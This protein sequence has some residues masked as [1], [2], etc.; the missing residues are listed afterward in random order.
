MVAQAVGIDLGTTFSCVGVFQH[1]KVEI[2][3]NEQGNRTTPSYVAFNDTERLI[4]DSAKNQIAMNPKN[5]VFDAKRLIGRKFNDPKIQQDMRLWPFEVISDGGNPKIVVEYK[6]EKRKFTPEEISSMVLSKMKEIAETYLGGIV[7]DAV[8]TVPAYFNDAQRQATKDAGAIAALNVLRIIN[9]PTAAALAYGLDKELKGEKNVLIFDL[10]GGTFDVS[11]L[12]ISEGS[13]FEVSSTAGDTH[14][15]GEDFDCRMVDHF[16]QEFERKYKKDIKSNPKALRRL[17]TACERAKRTLSSNTEASLEVDALHEGID[18]YSKITRARFEELCSDLFRQTLGPVDRALKDAGLN[19]RE[20]HDVVMVG[21]S[22]RIPKIQRLLQD[23]FS[24]KVLNLSINPDEAV[25]YGAA[26]QAAIL[27]GS[28][29]TRIQDVLLV[30][31]T[32]LSLGIETAGGIMTKLVDRNTRI[33]IA[34]KKIFTT[35]SDN[36]PAVTIQVFEGERAL[37]KDN[38]LLG[39]FN[40]TGIPPAPRGVPQVEVTFDIDA[41]GILS[42]SAQD[43]STGRSEQIT[44][45][46]DRGRLNKKEIEKMLQDAEKFKAEDEMV[47]KKVEVRNQLEAYLF[48]CK[49]AAES[50]G[51]RLTDDEKDAVITECSNQ[52][53]WLETNGDA[54]LAELE[55]RL[56]SAQAICQSAMMK[57]HAGGPSY[58]RPVSS[59]GPRVEEV[60]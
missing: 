54:S 49:T 3:A 46:N 24:G 59:G 29:D 9:E 44:I 32:P 21:G 34:Q 7:K 41:N 38:N 48:G 55:S 50:A 47:R 51:T 27:T 30:D 1:G 25:A 57:L 15:G 37:T 53:L 60:D 23:F 40:L 13:L 11:I 31:I 39:V 36:Q 4:G 10:G 19:T 42:V 14:L 12:Q 26:V 58:G 33:P 6:G 45:S 56:K 43:R 52:L 20:I 16:C 22:T 28:K 2:I 17:R 35:Y 5:T 8:I 18:F